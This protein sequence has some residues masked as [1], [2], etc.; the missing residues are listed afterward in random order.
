MLDEEKVS[1]IFGCWTSASR[2]AVRDMFHRRKE[3]L[4]FYPVQYEGVE[5]SSRIVY[6]GP[7]PNQQLLPAID[8]LT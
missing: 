3:G 2:K 7:T 5:E 6:L 4:L 8:F 1:V